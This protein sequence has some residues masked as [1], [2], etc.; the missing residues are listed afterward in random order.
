MNITRA[1][2]LSAVAAAVLLGALIFAL[3]VLRSPMPRS[4]DS[5]PPAPVAAANAIEAAAPA[6]PGPSELPVLAETMPEFT[7][8]VEWLNGGPET[9]TSLLGRVVLVHFWTFGCINCIHTMPYVV[10][11]YDRYVAQGFTVIGVHTPEFAYEGEKKSVLEAID[12]HGIRYPVPM[13]NGF[14]TWNLYNNQYWP[15]FYLYDSH[16][17]LRYRSVGEGGYDT[18]ERNIQALIA[19]K[20]R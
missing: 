13:D 4:L 3:P 9:S 1:L 11:W 2:F 7:G 8:I 14:K 15:A 20:E 16:G 17:R 5:V 18:M 12:R 6:P 19:E 10:A